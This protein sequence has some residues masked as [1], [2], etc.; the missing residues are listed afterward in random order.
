MSADVC[1][2]DHCDGWLCEEGCSAIPD[3]SPGQCEWCGDEGVIKSGPY[4]LAPGD[5][6][7]TLC[8]D[9]DIE[10]KEYWDEMF[11]SLRSGW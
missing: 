8:P 11:R 1:P 6:G 5:E 3:V 9:C 2:V 4:T 10:H 7:L